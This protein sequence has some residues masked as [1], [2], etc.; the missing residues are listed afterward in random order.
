[1]SSNTGRGGIALMTLCAAVA[2]SL[3]LKTE[4]RVGAQSGTA[5]AAAKPVAVPISGTM[6][7]GAIALYSGKAEDLTAN[8]YRRGS[9]SAPNWTV[10]GDG[11]ATPR[12]SDIT[13]KQEFGDCYLHVEFRTPVNASGNPVSGG[14]SG[15]GLQGRYEVQILNS[16]GRDPRQQGCGSLYSQKA[17]RVNASKKAGEWQSFDIVFRA[18]RLDASGKVTDQPRVTVFQN[19]VLVQN[20][21]SFNGPTGIQYGEFKDQPA[22]GPLVLQGDHDPVQFR[23][24]WIVPL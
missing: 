5:A 12:G 15:V 13:S 6:P 22:T 11:I 20:N 21:E 17:P 9:Q 24:I 2:G 14:N 7:S 18:P 8:W 1:M 23:K 19:G 4:V 3:A 16:Y 10:G